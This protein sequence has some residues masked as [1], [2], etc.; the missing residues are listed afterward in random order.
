MSA[1][2]SVRLSPSRVASAEGRD[3]SFPL[4]S[5]IATIGSIF[6]RRPLFWLCLGVP[7]LVA[8]VYFTFIAVPI[9]VS[10]SSLLVFKSQQEA[11]NLASMLSGVSGGGSTEGAYILQKYIASWAEFEKLRGEFD[12]EKQF[13]S[14]DVV[15]RY[16]GFPTLFMR[17][18]VALWHYYQ[19]S[20]EAEVNEQSGIVSIQVKGYEAG[21][22][23]QLAQ[24]ILSDTVSHIDEMNK[25]AERDYADNAIARRTAIEESLQRDEAALASY[26]AKIG[27]YDPGSLYVSQLALLNSLEESEAT[28]KSQYAAVAKA[29]PNNPV[30]ENMQKGIAAMA[31]KVAAVQSGFKI[32][33]EE[34]ATYQSLSVARENDVALL[35]EVNIA[36]QEAELN[37]TKN[38]YYLNVISPASNPRDPELPRRLKWV[39][40]IFLCTLLL[41]SLIR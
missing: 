10:N 32:L 25:Q 26:R 4:K 13:S 31:G 27:I 20:I 3:K 28:M 34:T 7:N 21:F 38:K 14:G 17:S 37:S 35:K 9:F 11:P 1:K 16:G 2:F 15:T 22:T 19:G 8:I 40:G 23:T 36:V 24:K 12:L 39:A 6:T 29:T 30:A 18:D 33:S 41:W 5:S